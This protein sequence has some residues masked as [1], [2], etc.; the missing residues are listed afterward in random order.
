MYKKIMEHY[1][2][3]IDGWFDY[4]G[5]YEQVLDRLVEDAKIVELGC[6]KGKSSSYLAVQSHNLKKNFELHFVDTWGGSP[7]H[8]ESKEFANAINED[9]DLI[10][11]QFVENISRVD[12]PYNIHRMTSLEAADLFENNSLDFVYFD[13]NHSFSYLTQELKKW[14]PKLKAGG[15]LA[16]HDYNGPV[17]SAVK[18][19]FSP[20]KIIPYQGWMAYSWIT[21]KPDNHL[22]PKRYLYKLL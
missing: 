8:F 10:Y 14:Y 18:A 22:E 19:F 9:N 2:E 13:T 15:I 4:D 11:N 3:E 20:M 1:Y 7:E 5:L 16:G 21:Y 17:M 12:Y 6:W